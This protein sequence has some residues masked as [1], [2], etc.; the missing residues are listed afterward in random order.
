MTRTFDSRARP[1]MRVIIVHG[2]HGGRDTNWFPWL[3]DTLTREGI[4]VLRP[5]FPTPA[6]QSLKAWFDVYD[7]AVTPLPDRPTMLV[8][9]SLGVAFCLRVAERSAS[10]FEGLCLAAGFIGALDLPDYDAINRTFFE[11]PFD[12]P[13]ILQNTN[14]TIHCWASDNDPYVPLPRSRCISEALNSELQIVRG[15]GHLGS[16]SSFF[17]FPQVSRVILDRFLDVCSR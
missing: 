1:G 7:A 11:T 3:D 13:R 16:E 12:W 4:E 15:G 14:K 5:Q 10:G 2:A 17:I 8:G 9:H 6:G